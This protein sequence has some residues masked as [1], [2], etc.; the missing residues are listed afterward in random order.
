[1]SRDF[2]STAQTKRSGDFV[3]AYFVRMVV[4]NWTADP[5]SSGILTFNNSDLDIQATAPE[6][7]VSRLYYGASNVL[8]INSIEE[9]SELKRN[10]LEIKFN[11]LSNTFLNLFL[12]ASYDINRTAIYVYDG[13]LSP[14]GTRQYA[15]VNLVR[16]H[17]GL[18]DSVKYST[19]S[20]QTIIAIRTVSQFS[21]WS[22]PRV[23]ELSD[24][25][26]KEKDSSDI[27]L[28]FMAANSGTLRQVT[29]GSVSASVS[30]AQATGDY[31]HVGP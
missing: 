30:P 31:R 10:G 14:V 7:T 8:A 9:S 2:N 6:D 22:R 12:T 16:V 15:S 19:S 21:D 27:S 3:R 5:F 28:Q 20:T 25:T 13:A 24:S 17:K 11:G 23:G 1:M 18:V 29:W 26:Q 4:P